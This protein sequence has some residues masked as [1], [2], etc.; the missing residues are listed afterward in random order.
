MATDLSISSSFALSLLPHSSS[1]SSWNSRR[2][3]FPATTKAVSQSA[4][5]ISDGSVASDRIA[6]VPVHRVTVSDR[7]RGW[8]TNSSSPSPWW[9]DAA[10]CAGCCTIAL[11]G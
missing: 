9:L 5:G 4:I 7:Q 6:A 1:S 8:Y 10:A 11:L 2:R 3:T